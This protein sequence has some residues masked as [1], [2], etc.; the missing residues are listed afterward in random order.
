MS[1]NTRPTK[2]PK[3][4]QS[5]QHTTPVR[6]ESPGYVYFVRDTTF[7]FTKIS[8][9]HGTLKQSLAALQ[10]GNPDILTIYKAIKCAPQCPAPEMEYNLHHK[11]AAYHIRGEWFEITKS[12]IDEICDAMCTAVPGYNVQACGELVANEE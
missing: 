7:G 8:R 2:M 5:K 1:K 11:F 3:R 4:A 10:F 9:A 6:T 12:Q